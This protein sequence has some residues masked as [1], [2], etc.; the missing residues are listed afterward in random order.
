MSKEADSKSSPSTE[1]GENP[2]KPP[3]QIPNISLKTSIKTFVDVTN[4]TLA[5]FEQAT[6]ESSA[7]FASRLMSFGRQARLFATRTMSVYDQRGSYGPQV[8]AGTALLVGSAFALRRGK[9]VGGVTG[10][11]AGAAAYG[12]VYG[13]Q[14]YSTSWRKYAPKNE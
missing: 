9:F 4:S 7:A 11:L 8:V 10:G 14:D 1:S 12:N 6:N 5:T 3:L 2:T 13:F